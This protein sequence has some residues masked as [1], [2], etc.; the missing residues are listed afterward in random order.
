[1]WLNTVKGEKQIYLIYVIEFS[2]FPLKCLIFHENCYAI[3]CIIKNFIK[4]N[5]NIYKLCNIAKK[6][7][8]YIIGLMS[9][10]S[11]DGLDIALCNISGSGN[12]THLEVL[13]FETMEYSSS[14][15]DEI[16]SVFSKVEVS[17]KML[18][19]M[20]AKIGIA[21]AALV[22][23]ALKKWNVKVS[24]V[25]LIASHGQTVF[26]APK[27]SNINKEFPNSTLQIGDGDHI[28]VN[29]GIITVSDFRQ[30]H[31]AA[32]GE[33]A[34]LVIYGDYLLFGHSSEN[35]IMLNIGGIS[36]FT[37]L[38]AGGQTQDLFATD[39]GPG[40]TLMNQYM[41][42]NYLR[43][44]DKE[45]EVASL[46]KVNNVLLKSL[47][48]YS[49]FTQ[50]FPK[51]TGPE[52]FNLNFLSDA[53]KKSNTELIDHQDVM[54]TLCLFTAKGIA[55]AILPIKEK[56]E[57]LCV[58]VSGGGCKNPLLR[59]NIIKE[60]GD[61]PIENTSV[62]GTDPEAKEAVLFSLLANEAVAGAPLAF[63]EMSGAPAVCFGKIS[64][65]S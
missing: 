35:R 52:V 50:N 6:K 37:F 48:D 53:Q 44:Y 1:L 7:S 61:V 59:E 47:L 36:N 14:F 8:R 56:Y 10:T 54:A 65:P 55:H 21:H 64:F 62:L 16:E 22:K 13:A 18:C 41:Q 39:V 60:L 58:Y 20:N 2:F 34:P 30:K 45:G 31:V 28:A 42:V 33:G 4:M 46:G 38:P 5:A 24:Q 40:N 15:R 3:V 63:P 11:L 29:T 25:D 12:Q 43:A 57:G 27:T 19:A 32:G 23:E 49:F 51:S 26:H 9:G 17:M